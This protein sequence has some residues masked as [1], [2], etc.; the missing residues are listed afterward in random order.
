MHT[1]TYVPIYSCAYVHMHRISKLSGDGQSVDLSVR[2]LEV[3]IV[4]KVHH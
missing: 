1:H 2:Y 4:W 3:R